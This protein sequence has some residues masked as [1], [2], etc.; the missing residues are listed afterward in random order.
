[1]QSANAKADEADEV[2]KFLKENTDAQTVSSAEL[3]SAN[4]VPDV[5]MGIVNFGATDVILPNGYGMMSYDTGK[6][7]T[8]TVVKTSNKKVC[9]QA[10]S[11][12]TNEATSVSTNESMTSEALCQLTSEVFTALLDVDTIDVQD[13]SES[14]NEI[15]TCKATIH[16][17]TDMTGEANITIYGMAPMKDNNIYWLTIADNDPTQSVCINAV[18]DAFFARTGYTE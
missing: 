7:H 18:E 9:I 15:P 13:T 8:Q 4:D 16:T 11:V 12:S 6:L 2:N 17:S 3:V 5:Y 10:H 1:V 14:S